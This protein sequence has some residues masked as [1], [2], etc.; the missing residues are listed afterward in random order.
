VGIQ[1]SATG[2]DLGFYA[3]LSYSLRRPPRTAR[4]LICSWERS[5]AGWSGRGGRC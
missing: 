3:G 4:R 5:A 1:S 2:L